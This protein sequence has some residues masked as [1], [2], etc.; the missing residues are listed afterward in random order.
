[1][2]TTGFNI[3]LSAHAVACVQL[4]IHTDIFFSSWESYINRWDVGL[5]SS[6]EVAWADSCLA[7]IGNEQGLFT[8]GMKHS[9]SFSLLEAKLLPN[10]I[11]YPSQYD[12]LLYSNL[13][14]GLSKEKDDN[15]SV[16]GCCLVTSWQGQCSTVV[17]LFCLEDTVDLWVF[18][19]R[20]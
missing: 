6:A 11:V 15:G 12:V 19:L 17:P 7:A 13:S 2:L 1:M 9:S 5:V 10:Q 3:L 8:C 16:I 20:C 14:C 18:L 4:A